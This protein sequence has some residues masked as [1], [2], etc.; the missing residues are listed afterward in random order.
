M[1]RQLEEVRRQRAA[2][3]HLMLDTALDMAEALQ[4]FA[5]SQ[6]DSGP[7][8]NVVR[9]AELGRAINVAARN[10]DA[11]GAAKLVSEAGK[12]VAL[13][14]AA[15]IRELADTS[16]LAGNATLPLSMNI[17]PAAR[18]YGRFALCLTQ[19]ARWLQR[20]AKLE[21]QANSFAKAPTPRAQ[22]SSPSNQRSDLQVQNDTVSELENAVLLCK[23][24]DIGNRA[25]SN[26][27]EEGAFYQ[28]FPALDQCRAIAEYRSPAFEVKN[29]ARMRVENIGR[30]TLSPQ[31]S[32]AS[33][34]A[35]STDSLQITVGN[36]NDEQRSASQKAYDQCL[37][38]CT[39]SSGGIVLRDPA[40][41]LKGCD[42]VLCPG[43]LR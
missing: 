7:A 34:P 2:N 35:L 33:Q 38:A 20:E 23:W 31:S 17:V 41:C 19:D 40:P 12:I 4:G 6:S 16:A 14:T 25:F 9:L 13:E 39:Q 5:T 15:K 43:L 1:K 8:A 27:A 18:M 10:G 30:R 32:L 26:E 42:R 37:N 11:M 28:R 3:Q 22:E 24:L 21:I 29:W 36:C